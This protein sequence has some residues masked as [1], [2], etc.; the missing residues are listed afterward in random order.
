MQEMDMVWQ[1]PATLIVRFW[2]QAQSLNKTMTHSASRQD[3]GARIAASPASAWS[4]LSLVD[5]LVWF[6]GG[7]IGRLALNLLL[8]AMPALWSLAVAILTGITAYA[9]YRATLAPRKDF[10]I[11]YR[12]FL[13]IGGVDDWRPFL[14]VLA[15]NF[16]QRLAIPIAQDFVGSDVLV[17]PFAFGV[18]PWPMFTV[19]LNLLQRP[20]LSL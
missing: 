3:G 2:Q 7:V 1:E 13:M 11:A 10:G 14:D 19:P 16:C 12:V 4:A 15:G 8:S 20:P 17:V 18:V 6:G 5:M 9:L